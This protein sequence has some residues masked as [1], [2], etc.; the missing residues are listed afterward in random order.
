MANAKAAVTES[1]DNSELEYLQAAVGS[2][3][4][5]QELVQRLKPEYDQAERVMNTR[6]AAVEHYLSYLQNKYQIHNND[7]LSF[8]N[9]S[10][11]RED[12]T[13]RID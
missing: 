10:I 13:N 5:S 9:G 1:I 3:K 2:L 12:V 7:K 11:L 4:E 6:Q 8:E